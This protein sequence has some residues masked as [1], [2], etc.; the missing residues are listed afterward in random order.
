MK[1]ISI[2]T[3]IAMAIAGAAAQITAPSEN[4]N[5]TSPSANAPY[6]AGQTLPC[7]VELFGDSNTGTL[8]IRHLF[9]FRSKYLY[10]FRS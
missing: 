10:I 3:G 9:V 6:V 7:T 4:Y 1:F 2:A 8:H 5:I